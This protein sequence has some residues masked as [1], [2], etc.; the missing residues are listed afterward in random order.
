MAL[1][2]SIGAAELSGPAELEMVAVGDGD[3]VG[4]G[5][6]AAGAVGRFDIDGTEDGVTDGWLPSS[7]PIAEP[8]TTATAKIGTRTDGRSSLVLFARS[9]TNLL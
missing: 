4:T 3:A 6:V 5:E 1:I 9:V 8:T 2:W 7:K